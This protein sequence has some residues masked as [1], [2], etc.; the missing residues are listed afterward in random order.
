[1]TSVRAHLG[2]VAGADLESALRVAG[3]EPGAPSDGLILAAHRP[4]SGG[5]DAAVAFLREAFLLVR[6]TMAAGAPIVTVLAT[7]DLLGRQGV[8]GAVVACGLL[9][10]TRTAAIEVRGVPVNTLATAADVPL[11]QTA[12]WILRLLAG[13]GVSGELVRLGGGH[14]GDVQ[15]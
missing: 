4:P 13:D 3:W 11:E 6:E 7:E 10:G 12:R 5:W 15:P 8:D 1:M 2:G 14:L 9:S